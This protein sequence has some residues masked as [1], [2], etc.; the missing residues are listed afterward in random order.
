MTV[1]DQAESSS[2]RERIEG[3]AREGVRGLARAGG[4]LGRGVKHLVTHPID[5]LSELIPNLM[6]LPE[7]IEGD[8]SSNDPERIGHAVGNVGSLFIG[9]G[10]SGMTPFKLAPEATGATV[11][12]FTGRAVATPFKAAGD[13]MKRPGLKNDLLTEQI[14]HTTAKTERATAQT[15]NTTASTQ[16]L[17]ELASQRA[18]KAPVQEAILMQRLQLLEKQLGRAATQDEILALRRD[19]QQ[20][21]LD[22]APGQQELQD[23]RVESAGQ[24][25]QLKPERIRAERERAAQVEERGPGSLEN[26]ELRNEILRRKLAGDVDSEAPLAP[27]DATTIEMPDRATHARNIAAEEA[28]N[29][30]SPSAEWLQSFVNKAQG[31][32]TKP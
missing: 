10:R 23:I 5:A 2:P 24:D 3:G 6:K 1:Y 32:R 14:K 7:Q 12:G 4:D 19:L 21:Q 31:K 28:A 17:E 20:A 11:A 8:L 13:L 25:L 22:R 16:A 15:E 18:G 27:S 30:R 9:G 26:L 29:P